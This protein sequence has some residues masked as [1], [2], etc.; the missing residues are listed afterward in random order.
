MTLLTRETESTT[1]PETPAEAL[2]ITIIRP[3]RGWIALNL[4]E[5]WQYRELLLFLAWRDVSVRYKQTA[6]GAAWAIIQPFVAMVIFSVVFGELA[7]IPSDDVPYPLF[8]YA[9][10]LPWQFFATALSSAA[11]SLVNDEK[12]ITK[13]YFP[14]LIIPVA[15]VLP[16]AIDFL[17]AFVILL[18]MMLFYHTLPTWRIVWLPLFLLLAA[19]TALG[20]GLWLAAFNVQYRDFRYVIPFLLQVWMY[21][22]PVVYSSTIIPERWRLLFGIN[23][24]TGVIGGFRWALLGTETA[25]GP[26]MLIS[27]ATALVFLIV[28][29][30]YFRRMESSFADVI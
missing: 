10:L 23:P 15:S 4:K 16:A 7:K 8:S 11:S 27:A 30:F 17:I 2:P 18:G 13:I 21:A 6:L 9:A 5:L 26:L 20:V 29:A 25:P 22:S 24:M 28:G 3:P 12:L 14:R 19:V 1:E